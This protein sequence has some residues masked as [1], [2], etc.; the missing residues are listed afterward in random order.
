MD[1]FSNHVSHVKKPVGS[2]DS[3]MKCEWGSDRTKCLRRESK[4]EE[5][6]SRESP[7][8]PTFGR[9]GGRADSMGAG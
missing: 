1:L 6:E 2:G 3:E 9:E 4:G 7:R 5:A 8:Q